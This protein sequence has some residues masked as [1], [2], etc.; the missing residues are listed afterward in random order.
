MVSQVVVLPAHQAVLRLSIGTDGRSEVVLRDRG[1][2]YT[3][4]AEAAA[5]FL[6]R[7]RRGLADVL[8]GSTVG[9]I[10]GIDV[11]WVLTLAEGHTTI[12]AGD[13]GDQRILFFQDKDG[14]LI[15]SLGLPIALRRDWV[16]RIDHALAQAGGP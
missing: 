12:F 6:P 16:E 4:G 10:D 3:L 13:L 14:Q 8:S 2:D 11:K 1:R 7:L 9:T 5:L 15:G